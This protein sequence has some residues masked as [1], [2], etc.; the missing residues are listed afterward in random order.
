[1]AGSQRCSYT[2]C[3]AQEA[4]PTPHRPLTLIVLRAFSPASLTGVR[5]IAVSRH[6]SWEESPTVF[7]AN[8]FFRTLFCHYLNFRV[9]LLGLA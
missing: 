3:D 9:S 4:L 7:S 1:M 5:H 2:P 8:F 6:S